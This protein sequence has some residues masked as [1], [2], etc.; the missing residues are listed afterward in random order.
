MDLVCV[1]HVH[2]PEHPE[3]Y[4]RGNH[5]VAKAELDFRRGQVWLEE[6]LLGDDD[7]GVNTAACVAGS[8]VARRVGG[9]AGRGH[10]DERPRIQR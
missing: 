2:F 4:P 1:D 10:E 8:K 5:R 3:G 7:R 9:L 6:D